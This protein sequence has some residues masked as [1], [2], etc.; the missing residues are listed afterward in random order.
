[1]IARR[2]SAQDASAQSTLE[3]INRYSPILAYAL[4]AL[5][6]LVI[7]RDFGMS[8]DEGVQSEYGELVLEYFRS[9][10]EETAALDYRNLHLYGTLIELS[11]AWWYDGTTGEWI[12][13]RHLWIGLVGLTVVPALMALAKNYDAS[14]ML[15]ILAAAAMLMLPRYNGH[16]FYN[17]KDVPLAATIAIAI[18][19]MAYYLQPGRQVW[20]RAILV[21]VA[22]GTVGAIRPAGLPIILVMVAA[23]ALALVFQE[24]LRDKKL[25]TEL[26]QRLVV[27]GIAVLAIA[28]LIMIALWPWAHQAPISNPAYAMLYAAK[29]PTPGS[30]FFEGTYILTTQLP[31]SYLL[32]NLLLTTPVSVLAFFL[33]GLVVLARRLSQPERDAFPVEVLIATWLALPLLMFLI[34]VPVTGAGIH[35][36]LFV[37]PAI[38]F[39]AAIGANLVAD[40]LATR[41][42]RITSNIIVIAILLVPLGDQFRLHPYQ[43]S[44]YS[45]LVGGLKSA[46]HSFETDYLVSS[47]RE[48]IGW[49]NKHT[50]DKGE[51]NVNVLIAA[52]NLSITTASTFASSRLNLITTL[53]A[54]REPNLPDNIDYYISSYRYELDHN[55]P[56]APVIY[57]VKREGIRFMVVKGRAEEP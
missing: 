16:L 3:T 21:A 1:M 24:Y 34:L 39:I 20:G 31:R 45:E 5:G 11:A 51:E 35:H 50:F 43:I 8:W 28:W 15:P 25:P 7:Y 55:F 9:L 30:I 6:S 44:Y 4:L 49:L 41:I 17:S 19:A 29:F 12:Y 23:G 42:S 13:I 56:E 46:G 38:A 47:H 22:M 32:H 54:S 52:N 27:Q 2:K 33:P 48:A 10:G 57:E 53:D 14:I 26:L 36:F 18:A 37:L 40:L